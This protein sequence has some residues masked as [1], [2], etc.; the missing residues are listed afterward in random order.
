MVVQE[1]V[2]ATVVLLWTPLGAGNCP[3]ASLAR[4]QY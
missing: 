2:K 1:V 3:T 4:W